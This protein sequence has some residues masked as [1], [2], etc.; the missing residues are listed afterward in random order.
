MQ[1]LSPTID[2]IKAIRRDLGHNVRLRCK[3]KKISPQSVGSTFVWV[4][5][6]AEDQGAGSL[7]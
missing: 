2:E 6:D 3:E 4:G 1:F 7:P 5:H